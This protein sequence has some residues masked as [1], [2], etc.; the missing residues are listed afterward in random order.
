MQST[1]L[2]CPNCGAPLQVHPGDSAV[3]CS[4]CGSDIRITSDREAVPFFGASSER[5]QGVDLAA[6]RREL[7]AGRKINA[8]KLVREQTGLGLK[9][10]LEYVEALEDTEAPSPT[11][12]A[13]TTPPPLPADLDEVTVLLRSG[14]KIEA[15][16]RYRELRDT[17][18][19]EAKAAV[20]ALERGE[21]IPPFSP[22]AASPRDRRTELVR[23]RMAHLP[24][25][26]APG[27]GCSRIGLW[28]V[29]FMMLVLGGCGQYVRTTE[30]HACAVDLIT[31]NA[32]MRQRLG[33]PITVSPLVLVMGYSSETDFG[34]NTDRSAGYFAIAEGPNDSAWLYVNAF[35]NST[36]FYGVRFN[37]IPNREDL[38]VTRTGQIEE[39]GRPR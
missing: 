27:C 35:E 3:T 31:T 19:T 36:G 25:G 2:D 30:L 32:A 34:G 10:S 28:I 9:E 38:L 18:L 37:P 26:A 11:E 29:L 20:D 12:L 33:S 16:K 5:P 7:A 17:S 4:H 6:V 24:T 39:C 8:V 23:E 21:S 13:R 1:S 15:I 22:P 14:N